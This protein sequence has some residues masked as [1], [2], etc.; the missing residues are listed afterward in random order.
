MLANILMMCAKLFK[1]TIATP[2]LILHILI[3]EYIC[4]C[5]YIIVH[6][7]AFFSLFICVV[8]NVT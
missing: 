1:T 3:D 4:M 8:L 2:L 5:L 7:N 6:I